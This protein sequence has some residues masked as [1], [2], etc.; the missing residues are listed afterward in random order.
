VIEG[1]D[2]S[3]SVDVLIVGSG[4]VG[5]TY[6]RILAAAVPSASVLMLD[7][8][9]ALTRV[10][11]ANLK[12]FLPTG[13]RSDERDG[14]EA[15]PTVA[16][17]SLARSGTELFD[18]RGPRPGHMPAAAIS[19]NVGGMGAHWSCATPEPGDDERIGL[20]DEQEWDELLGVAR[21]LLM[22]S[23]S[24]FGGSARGAAI[25]EILSARF[26]GLLNRPVQVMPHACAPLPDGRLR[27]AG[28]D[29][30]LGP[31]IEATGQPERTGP[32]RLEPD[33]MCRRLVLQ[34]GTVT[35]AEVVHLPTRRT[36]QINARAVVVAAD[37]LR[38]PQL[39]WASGIRPP[40]LGHYLNEHPMVGATAV[41]D[42]VVVGRA[43]QIDPDAAL[44]DFAGDP[45][46]AVWVPYAG[47]SHRFSGQ[48]N[49]SAGSPAGFA[50]AGLAGVPASRIVSLTWFCPKPPRYKD[51]IDFL[52][53]LD[54]DGMPLP[55]VHYSMSDED[56]MIVR[57][58][59]ALA[60]AA[61]Q[62]MGRFVPGQ[63]PALLEAGQSLHYMG[64]VRMGAA[65][66]GTCVCDPYSRVWGARG[67]Y[68]GG[69]GVIPTATA[70]N[71]TLTS[72]ALAVRAARFLAVDLVASTQ[73]S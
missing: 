56:Q 24:A 48:I 19:T 52:E 5:A 38:T 21:D 62:A 63:E 1:A 66:D 13:A 35:G 10:P 68:V 73:L 36:R 64:T 39:L 11:G 70:C 12:N 71:P 72:V 51:R 47:M 4:P 31:L 32:F 6:A 27:W 22:S 44:L 37:S 61:G 69:N 53:D 9:P 43:G 57:E 8:G 41:L 25:I 14:P 49:T 7:R 20:I 42:D 59:V 17:A 3:E 54:A 67:L 18:P 58:G 50:I 30:V 33:T 55:D 65:D 45:L 26:A 60:C 34:D 2:G 16:A 29:T 40:A 46:A 23:T 15:I 28:A